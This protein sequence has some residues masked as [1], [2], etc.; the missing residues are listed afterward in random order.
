MEKI[1][2]E[3]L[4]ITLVS[5]FTVL[6]MPSFAGADILFYEDFE[7]EPDI[8]LDPDRDWIPET[9]GTGSM[10]LSAEQVRA[11]SKSY[12]FTCTGSADDYVR[13]ELQLRNL[14]NDGTFHFIN[15]NENWI[16]FSIFLADGY[17]SPDEPGTWGVNHHQY[18]NFAD[19]PPTCDWTEIG[20][21]G[22][23]IRVDDGYW[24]SWVHWDDQQCTP[25][26]GEGVESVYYTYDS[27]VT[28]QWVDF[29]INV[30]WS[31]ENDGFLKIWKDGVL[32]TDKT[33]GTCHNDV[34]GPYMKMGIYGRINDEQVMTVYFDEFRLGDNNANYAEV[35]P[36][37]TSVPGDFDGDGCVDIADLAM[38][39]EL[40][41]KCNDP[42]NPDCEFPF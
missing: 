21:K 3:L 2:H 23:S 29:V 25:I 4:K 34:I 38:F 26:S 37:F 5:L 24:T 7:D 39:A 11:G 6:L 16:G 35:A 27:S 33:G 15:G 14:F 8:T 19:S 1:K 10:E 30:K 13:Q 17:Y 36:E 32:I 12:K 18:H 31:Y 40:W 20:R 41:L 9:R 42:Q 28:G 22:I